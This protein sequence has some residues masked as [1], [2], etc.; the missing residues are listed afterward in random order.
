MN[1]QQRFLET[2]RYGTPDHVPYF[3]EGIRKGVIKAWHRQGLQRNDDLTALFPSDLRME[4]S[5]NLYPLPRMKK[6]P[7]TKADLETLKRRLNPANRHRLPTNWKQD[8]EKMNEQGAV[9]MLE[10]HEGFFLT[11]GVGD[12]Q[13]F[14]D[15]MYMIKDDPGLVHEI[16]RV[17]GEFAAEMAQRILSQTAVEA[18][19][20]SEPIGGNNGPIISP[21]TYEDFVLRSYK[22]ILDVI[23]AHQVPVI[24]V[25]TYAN[26]RVLIPS[27][28]NWGLNCLWACEVNSEEMNYP[29]LRREFG[30]DL[31]LIGGIDLDTL[32]EGKAAI[33]QEIGSK[34]PALLKDGGYIPLAD[35]RV[36]ED[37][38]YENYVYYRE[39]LKEI[40]GS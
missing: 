31:R 1:S 32:R 6:M 35:G 39:L 38:P 13:R 10:V 29:D 30:R 27:L 5:P 22:P 33:R 28:I 25:R 23:H 24:I 4:I 16:L 2:M 34:V 19:I 12:W 37:V 17:Q 8:L 21:K 3:E 20:F 40:I 26:A 11:M 18:V 7:A 14:I 15:V 36:R 9:R